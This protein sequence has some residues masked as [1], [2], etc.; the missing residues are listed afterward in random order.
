MASFWRHRSVVDFDSLV[1]FYLLSILFPPGLPL[2]SPARRD[3][4]EA[5]P[6]ALATRSRVSLSADARPRFEW[7]LLLSCPRSFLLFGICVM[8]LLISSTVFSDAE[9]KV[10][11]TKIKHSEGGYFIFVKNPY[12]EMLIGVSF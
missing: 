5:L 1:K 4:A 11:L 7:L 8:L 6:P 12:A 10:I 9:H 2:L 3:S